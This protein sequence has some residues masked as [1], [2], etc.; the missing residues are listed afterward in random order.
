MKYLLFLLAPL[1]AIP[2]IGQND[3][4]EEVKAVCNEYFKVVEE[5]DIEGTLNLMHPILFE[6]APREMIAQAMED[7][8]KDE[9]IQV[10]LTDNEILKVSEVIEQKGKKFVFVDYRF[11]MKMV[12]KDLDFDDEEMM[13]EMKAMYDEMYGEENVKINEENKSIDIIATNEMF[14]IEEGEGWKFLENK[15]NM[16][17][18]IE[19]VIPKEVIKELTK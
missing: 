19:K 14:L 1:F 4:Q 5:K 13:D 10:E 15:E 17:T 18:V 3:V 9:V 7:M 6:L 11:V 12:M 8:A 2:L 16:G